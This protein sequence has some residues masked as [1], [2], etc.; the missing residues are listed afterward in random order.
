MPLLLKSSVTRGPLWGGLCLHVA[1]P[2]V[3]AAL[4]HLLLSMEIHSSVRREESIPKFVGWN[5]AGS[6]FV[7]CEGILFW[8]GKAL[9]IMFLAKISLEQFWR[10][11]IQVLLKSVRLNLCMLVQEICVS[12]C[13]H[14]LTSGF[15]FRCDV[16]IYHH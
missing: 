11:W 1:F 15:L 5:M 4:F 16:I 2:G 6:G 10:S 8:F 13:L 7:F 9:C 12:S 14:P 3:A